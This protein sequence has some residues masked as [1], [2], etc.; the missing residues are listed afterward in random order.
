[1]VATPNKNPK[2]KR[3]RQMATKK[4]TSTKKTAKATSA[5]TKAPKAKKANPQKV[6]VAPAESKAKKR[7]EPKAKAVKAE[8]KLSQFQAAIKVLVEAKE[9]MGC[10]EMVEIMQAKGYWS[11]LAGKTPAQTLYAAIL[12]DIRKG[13][14]ARFVKSERGLFALASKK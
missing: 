1:M 4:T 3:E 13:K 14:D 7:R 10:K 12:R 2:M 8:K 6:A 11:S 9:P 5:K